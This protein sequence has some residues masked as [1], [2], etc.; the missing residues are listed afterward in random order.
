VLLV[1]CPARLAA[2]RVGRRA[3]AFGLAVAGPLAV[4]RRRWLVAVRWVARPPSALA[5]RLGAG[6]AAL[7]APPSLPGVPLPVPP[8]GGFSR[9]PS[10]FAPAVSFRQGRLF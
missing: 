9:S 1:A 10:R 4:S 3:A 6:P 8:R 2:G 7:S 5:V